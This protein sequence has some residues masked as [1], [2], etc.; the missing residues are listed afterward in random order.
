MK[1]AY[2]VVLFKTGGSMQFPHPSAESGA[3]TVKAFYEALGPLR[4][5]SQWGV[6]H[7]DSIMGVY[8]CEIDQTKD[9]KKEVRSIKT[10]EDMIRS[11]F[12]PE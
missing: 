10:V 5:I 3:E 7:Q 6:F 12:R 1:Q 9:M 4:P 11:F 2:V 8:V